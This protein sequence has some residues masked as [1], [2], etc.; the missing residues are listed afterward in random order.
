MMFSRRLA[1]DSCC[2]PC[3]MQ[4]MEITSPPGNVIGYIMQEW[5]LFHSKF[6]VE[7]ASGEV[8]MRIEGPFWKVSCGASIDFS[9]LSKDATHLIGKIRKRWSGLAQEVFSNA[10]NYEITFPRDLHVDMKSVILGACFLIDFMFYE[11]G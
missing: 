7:D 10:D 11:S 2:F 3:C 4:R 8:V 6:R 1:C 9:I 5:S